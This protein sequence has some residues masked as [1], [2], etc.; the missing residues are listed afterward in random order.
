[1]QLE[2]VDN[3]SPFVHF[4]FEKRGTGR[5]HF[6]VLICK[7]ACR[8]THDPARRERGDGIELTAEQ[9]PIHL[10]DEHFGEPERTSL[11][12]AGDTVLYKP[13]ADLIITGAARPPASLRSHWAVAIE[14]AGKGF[15]R[16]REYRLLGPRQWQWSWTRGWHLSEPAEIDSL[17]LRY[18]LAFGGHY[19][20]AGK[21][22]EHDPNPVG[23]GFFDAQRMDRERHYPAP[24][25][26]AF[27]V[28]TEQPGQPVPSPGFGP[29]PRFWHA[30]S[31]FAGTYDD[32]WQR[33]A[34]TDGPDYPPDF[35]LRFF[36][37]AHPDW[38]FEKPFEG[39]EQVALRCFDGDAHCTGRLPPIRLEA[40]LMAGDKTAVAPMRLDT[41]EVELDTASLY[42]TWRLTIPHTLQ[43]RHAVVRSFQQG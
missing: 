27:E 39:G 31:R 26:E 17:P 42:L 38:I 10:A 25:I 32:D 40:L 18:E 21:W 37:A 41:V 9:A 36:Q 23:M 34:A 20:R 12:V 29:I 28:S 24:Q 8:L 11:R 19:P 35:D 14:V 33:Q 43:V 4:A 22:I 13:G 16:K 15:K 5:R 6:D 2:S 30:R 7:A 1:M 3:Y